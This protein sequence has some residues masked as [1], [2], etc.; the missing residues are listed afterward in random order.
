MHALSQTAPWKPSF[1]REEDRPIRLLKVPQWT[2][3]SYAWLLVP[4]SFS[5]PKLSSSTPNGHLCWGSLSHLE[6]SI[7][8]RICFFYSFL[9]TVKFIEVSIWECFWKILHTVKF[10]LFRCTGPWIFANTQKHV[11]ITTTK[12]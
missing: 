10:I 9:F 1:C 2:R 7:H 4:C 5:F 8:S 12:I 6:D 11:N 3:T